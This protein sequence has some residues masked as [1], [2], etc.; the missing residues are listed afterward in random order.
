MSPVALT[1]FGSLFILLILN[2]PIAVSLALSSVVTLFIFDIPLSIFPFTMYTATAKFT[3]LAIPFFILA[4]TIM[5]K[6]GISKRLINF[7][8]LVVG[9]LKGGL[10]IVTVLTSCFFAAISGSGPA[11]VAA[12]GNMLVPA[13]EES[14]Y[15]KGMSAA[16]LSAS[17]AIGIIIP[18]SIAFVVYGVV[19]QVS[20]GKLFIAGII[21]GL[22]F[23]LTLIVAS[24]IVS[25][26]YNIKQTGA[27][28]GKQLRKAFVEAI[29][30]IMTPVIILGGI[31]GGI[32]TPTEAAGVAV[33]YG[34]IV[35]LFIYRDL[36]PK[37][38]PSLLVESSVSS[39][40]VM[41][42]VAAASL[43]AWIITTQGIARDLA[44]V[45]LSIT[46]NKYGIL[47]I[48]NIILLIAGCFIDAVSAYYI[49]M[50]IFLPILNIVGIDLL[51]FGVV[52]TVNLAIGQITPPVGVN[53]YVACGIADIGINR[54][55]K[56]IVPFLVA[57]L[58]ALLLV[59]YLPILSLGL[60]AL[61]G[62]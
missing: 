38:V 58:V 9:H 49:L 17:G 7:A 50:P 44:D 32:F 5:E 28:T 14:G 56:S 57:S 43:F 20:I 1:L 8:N 4:G 6:S 39:A 33:F 16:L 2:V 34:L 21:P 26:K 47:M 35:G 29:W 62:M 45:L 51:H 40:V 41:L 12:L 31:Y 52:M 54:I 19:A 13:M 23:G 25:R 46:S 60:P 48:I 10:A 30:G 42:I 61:M 22:L 53:L 24:L 15:D 36:K 59:T 55:S 3:L 11:T 37:A 27:A 18:P